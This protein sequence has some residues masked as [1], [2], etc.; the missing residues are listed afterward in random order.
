MADAP[1][2]PSGPPPTAPQSARLAAVL[3]P[4]VILP[5]MA[6]VLLLAVLWTPEVSPVDTETRLTTYSTSPAAAGGFYEV[7]KRLGWRTNRRESP[8]TEPLDTDAVYAVLAPVMALTPPATHALLEAVR[9]GAGLIYVLS[10]TG[11]VED[12]LQIARSDSG[13]AASPSPKAVRA[14]CPTD[15]V[16]NMLQWFRGGVH[17]Y[18]VVAHRT[19]PTDMTVFVTVDL[20]T[21]SA[22]QVPHS[23]A[24]GVFS[25]LDLPT[26]NGPWLP[27]EPAAMVDSVLDAPTDSGLQRSQ[28]PAALGY[29]LGRGRVVVFSDPDMLRNDVVRVCR[30]GIGPRVLAALDWVSQ[31]RRPPLVFD[32]YDQGYGAQPST[33]WAV[34]HFL[35]DSTAGRGIAQAL[36][37]GLVLILALGVRP[38]APRDV[39]RIERRSPLEHVD[40][41]ARA[42]ERIGATRLAARRLAAGLRRRHGR[43]AW[44]ARSAGAG[45]GDA[46]ERFLAAVVAGHPTIAPDAARIVSA[47]HTLVTPTDLLAVADAVDH[48]D[49]VFPSPKP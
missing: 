42:Y 23:A 40:A 16:D 26:S 28:A 29:S 36:L 21:S 25:T 37:A 48:I 44:S 8:I 39:P 18:R 14:G 46:D 24:P 5:V 27:H 15:A 34:Q 30:W 38:I 4:R 45:P 31:G 11:V 35:F 47:E 2:T 49:Q 41:L 33:W 32:E 20:P 1:L 19:L 3:R 22:P 10:D 12:S 6:V 43:G 13:Y 17:L 9:H 7:A